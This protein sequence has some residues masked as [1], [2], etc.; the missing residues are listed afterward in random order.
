MVR[1]PLIAGAFLNI[2]WI[3]FVADNR[4]F[5]ADLSSSVDLSADKM[6]RVALQSIDDV[7][8]IAQTPV[9]AGGRMPVD[10]SFL[11]N[12]LVS[13]LNDGG[14]TKGADSFTFT[15]AGLKLGD[16]ATFEWSANYARVRHYKPESFGQGG[17]L[18]RDAAAKQWQVIVRKNAEAVR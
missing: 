6:R 15:L 14:G 17:G 13:S 12:S 18:F 7:V 3:G 9:S 10:T 11:R 5:I 16:F 2:E 8:R 4:K 1:K